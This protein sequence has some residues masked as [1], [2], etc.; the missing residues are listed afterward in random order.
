MAAPAMFDA[1]SGSREIWIRGA[2]D[3]VI[4]V[5][6]VIPSPRRSVLLDSV[7]GSREVLLHAQIP[8]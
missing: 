5:C 2:S 6:S 4:R 8:L 1:A 7:S 3:A